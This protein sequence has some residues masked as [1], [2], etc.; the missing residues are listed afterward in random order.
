M[1]PAARRQ[2]AVTDDEEE[3]QRPRN[4]Q[5]RDQSD[6]DSEDGYAE[7]EPQGT[8]AQSSDNQ[9]IKK[10]VRY[11]LACEFSRTPIR[12]DGIREKVLGDQGRAFKRVFEGAQGILRTVFGMEMVE[13]PVKDRLT[14]EEKR[15]GISSR[16]LIVVGPKCRTD[17]PTLMQRP[18][19]R[20]R[21]MRRIHTFSSHGFPKPTRHPKSLPRRASF[22]RMMRLLI[23]LSTPSSSP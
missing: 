11:A 7:D 14:K 3:D 22:L 20:T 8:S 9:L 19:P 15:K 2:R 5:R 17:S 6:R 10:L 1:P 18:N 12:R 4:R 21:R 16:G 23:S 13:L